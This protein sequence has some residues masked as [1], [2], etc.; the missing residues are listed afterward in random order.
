MC[1]FFDIYNGFPFKKNDFS[2][3]GKPILTIKNISTKKGIVNIDICNKIKK[4]PVNFDTNLFIKNGDLIASLTGEQ[5]FKIAF[6]N[7]SGVLNQRNIKIVAK[8]EK[9][10]VILKEFLSI[11]SITK[12]INMMATGAQKN[13]S[14]SQLKNMNISFPKNNLLVESFLEKKAKQLLFYSEKI[15]KINQIKRFFLKNIFA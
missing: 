14:S 8:G 12:Q 4:L 5:G 7:I 15:N 3:S 2:K 1:F 11:K 13:I 10:L 9:S 6:C